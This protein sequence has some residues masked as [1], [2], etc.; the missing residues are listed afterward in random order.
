MNYNMKWGD[1][2]N[3]G[4]GYNLQLLSFENKLCP[5]YYNNKIKC[6]W[7]GEIIGHFRLYYPDYGYDEFS[8]TTNSK[9]DSNEIQIDHILIKIVGYQA[10]LSR[11][12]ATLKLLIQY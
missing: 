11:D 12:N 4:D 10:G 5:S 3:I 2:I 7:Q 6:F 9:A 8:L 1:T